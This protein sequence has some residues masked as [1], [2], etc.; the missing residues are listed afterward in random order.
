MNT[1]QNPIQ[2]CRPCGWRVL[3]VAVLA[4]SWSPIGANAQQWTTNALPPGLVAWWQAE[5]NFLDSVGTNHGTPVGGVT[6]APGR[7]GQDFMFSGDGQSVSIPHAAELNVPPT[8]FTV[9]FWM[10]AGKD[11]P[12]AISSIV[13]KDHSA[14]DATGWE[15]SCWR[16]SGQLSFGIGDGSTFPLCTNFTDV[17]DNQFHHVAF[18]WDKTN[19]LIYVNGVLENSLYRPVVA[20]NSR[21]LRFGFHWFEATQIPGRFLKGSL[22]DV[23]IYNRALTAAEIAYLYAGPTLPVTNGLKL[24]FNAGNVIGDG[25]NPTDGAS[26]NTWRDL[27]SAGLDLTPLFS[28]APVYRASALNGRAGVDFSQSGSDALATAFSSQLNFTNCTIFMVGNDASSGTHVSISADCIHQ[29]FCLYDKG[30]QHHSSPYHYIYR[31]HQAAPAGFYIHAALF[32]VTAGQLVNLINGVVSSNGFVFGQQSPT[33]NDVADYAPVARQAILGWRNSDAN[34]NP[35]SAVENFGGVIC[36]VLVY[37]RQLTPDELG[38]TTAYLAGK[39]NLPLALIRPV[40]QV[41][42]IT[43][44]NA[45]LQWPTVCGRQYQLQSSTNLFSAGWNNEGAPFIGTGGN[46]ST[47]VFIGSEAEKFFRLQLIGN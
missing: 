46:L 11:Q 32:G 22:D 21:P 39:Y 5:N 12:E 42:S 41:N 25:S 2:T 34:C 43:S 3:A 6:F 23:R 33:L 26:V 10:K 30:I 47:S 36:E 38:V 20:N 40:I 27:G 19:W 17:L 24:W 15:V 35:P 8:G 28:V 45:A 31:S 18:A 7:Y 13:D 9:E 4:L 44:G 14:Q 29:E 1:K 37:D 16:D